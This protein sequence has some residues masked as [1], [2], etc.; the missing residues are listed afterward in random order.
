MRLHFYLNKNSNAY[1]F[2][3][4]AAATVLAIIL[5]SL[6]LPEHFQLATTVLTGFLTF[7]MIERRL[8]LNRIMIW[9]VQQSPWKANSQLALAIT[10]LFLG[11]FVTFMLY[12]NTF[13]DL[14]IRRLKDL[15][16]YYQNDWLPLLI[17]NFKVLLAGYL[18]SVFYQSKGLLLVIVWNS[19]QWAHSFSRMG[20]TLFNAEVDHKIVISL[21]MFSVLPHLILEVTAFILACLAGIFFSKAFQK[22]DL[23]SPAFLRVSRACI[24]ILFVSTLILA[25]AAASEIYFAQWI[26]RPLL[27]TGR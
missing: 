21:K 5:A 9:E 19:V 6:I 4:G 26:V 18:L 23:Q 25:L 27:L 8:D 20:Q 7:Q 24:T 17:H 15:S 14:P 16:Q 3:R 12:Y 22:Y 13:A 1:A 10:L 11:T 2:T